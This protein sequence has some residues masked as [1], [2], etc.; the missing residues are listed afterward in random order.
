MRGVLLLGAR[1]WG[2]G[3]EGDFE[4]EGAHYLW[5]ELIEPDVSSGARQ[6]QAALGARHAKVYCVTYCVSLNGTS[7]NGI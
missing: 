2:G 6:V 5:A 1:T 3:G 4:R 7:L